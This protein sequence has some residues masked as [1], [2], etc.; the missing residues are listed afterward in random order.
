MLR[1]NIYEILN[2]YDIYKGE[3]YDESKVVKTKSNWIEI[4]NK[5]SKVKKIY[6]FKVK[7]ENVRNKIY[8]V[9]VLM[10]CKIG[11]VGIN[12]ECKRFEVASSCKHVAAAIHKYYND[13]FLGETNEEKSQ[14]YLN[15]FFDF[16]EDK[17]NEKK[18][19]KKGINIE[20]HLE[21][22]YDCA[23]K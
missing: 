22:G 13:I 6:Y 17:Y 16:F 21:N 18:N 9:S 8:N 11:I 14:R 12:C 19:I 20:I 2:A 7:S 15:E 23:T 5:E 1:D 3:E 10:D 4:N